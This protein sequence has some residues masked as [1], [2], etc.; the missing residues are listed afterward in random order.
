MHVAVAGDHD[1]RRGD[2]LLLQVLEDLDAVEDRHLDVEK[3]GV[4]VR[5]GGLV[6]SFL[7][8]PRFLH[9]IAFVLQS[10]ANRFA[11]GGLVVDD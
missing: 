7:A 6:E 3:D 2:L 5:T 9:A 8:G 10:H 1:H 4:V 11:D